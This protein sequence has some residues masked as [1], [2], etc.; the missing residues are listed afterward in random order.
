MDFGR[1]E[2]KFDELLVEIRLLRQAITA[3][4]EREEQRRRHFASIARRERDLD[5]MEVLTSNVED[6]PFSFPRD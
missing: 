6:H 2:H 3:P 1:L 5:G 4:L